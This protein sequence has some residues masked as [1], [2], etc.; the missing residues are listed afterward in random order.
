MTFLK[1]KQKGSE[2]DLTTAG[3]ILSGLIES[4]QK[5][6][7]FAHYFEWMRKYLPKEYCE[8]MEQLYLDAF[9]VIFEKICSKDQFREKMDQLVLS[10][11]SQDAL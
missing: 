2:M 6:G 1:K 9:L 11:N 10:E 3:V 4:I 8:Q 7:G 5:W